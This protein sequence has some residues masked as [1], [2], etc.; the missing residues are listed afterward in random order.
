MCNHTFQTLE[1]LSEKHES[2]ITAAKSLDNI[3]KNRYCNKL[4][5]E[6][7]YAL[8]DYFCEIL[9]DLADVLDGIGC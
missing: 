9:S 8:I 3:N 2:I 7:I 4:P 5:C 1:H 6:Y